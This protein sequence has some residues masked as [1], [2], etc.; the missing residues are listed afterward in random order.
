VSSARSVP[1]S[2]HATMEYVMPPLSNNR[3]ARDERCLLRGPYR[4][5]ISRTVS[6]KLFFGVESV[7][8]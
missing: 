8:C 6:E 1:I 4:D 3:T 2:A 7:G 5:V